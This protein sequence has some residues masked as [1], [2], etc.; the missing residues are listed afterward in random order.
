MLPFGSC[1]MKESDSNY[2]YN[3]VY[4]KTMQTNSHDVKGRDSNDV[5]FPLC[6]VVDEK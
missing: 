1:S 2:S 4:P 5:L 3:Y 6:A